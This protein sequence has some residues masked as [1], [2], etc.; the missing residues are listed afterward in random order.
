M[1]F[2]IDHQTHIE[3]INESHSE[4]IFN[5]VDTNRSFL[6]KWLPF[7]D[8]MQSVEFAEN[9]V[10]GTI[11]RNKVGNEYAFVIIENEGL[12]G[13][14][15][16]Y[17]IDQENKIAEI[18]YWLAENV[19]GRGIVTSA[20]KLLINFCFVEL[21]LNRIEIRCGKENI[22]SRHIAERLSFSNEGII[23]QGELVEN[24]YIDLC[25]YSLLSQ[26]YTMNALS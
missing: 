11:Q 4:S 8:K 25:L 2:K 13:R 7:V 12:L 17:K 1:T 22:K 5:I 16:I 20:C 6:R 10:K 21:K 3:L 26:E 19:Q 18:G 15:G 23:R 24:K 9:F 14:V